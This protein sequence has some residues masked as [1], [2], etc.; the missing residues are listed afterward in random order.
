MRLQIE[1]ISFGYGERLVLDH[2]SLEDDSPETLCILGANGTGK[3]T[4]LGCVIGEYQLSA[5]CIKVDGRPVGSIPARSFARKVAFIPQSHAPSFAFPCIDVVAM[6]RTAHMGYFANPRAEDIRI[7]EEKLEHLG[8]E[9][10]RDKPY[11]DISGG[12]RQLV[13][14]A[15]ALAQAPET[16]VFDEPTAHLDF[17]NAFKFIQLVEKLRQEGVGVIMTTHFP[18]HALMLHG[19]TAVLANGRIEALGCAY[20][21]VTDE[22]MSAL[23]GIETHVREV[24]NRSICIPGS[25]N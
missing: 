10:L 4:L 3:S 8:I 16:I 22:R 19:T 15:S 20:D 13:M 12:E 14:I 1:D 24:E 9:R 25:L 17:G 23:Y 7:A 2:C 21:I 6:G 5:G 18:D 11:T